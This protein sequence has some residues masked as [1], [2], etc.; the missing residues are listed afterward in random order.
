MSARDSR[1]PGRARLPTQKIMYTP[2]AQTLPWRPIGQN[3]TTGSFNI[4]GDLEQVPKKFAYPG[5]VP[6]VSW[7]SANPGT[8]LRWVNTTWQCVIL[9]N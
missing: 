2:P 4:L 7:D 6:A 9:G 8:A 1:L 5:P 3:S